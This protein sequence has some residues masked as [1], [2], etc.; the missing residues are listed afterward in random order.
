M[1]LLVLLKRSYKSWKSHQPSKMGASLAYYAILSLAPLVIIAIGVAGLVFG[2]QAARQGLSAQVQSLAGPEGA[3]VIETMLASA[4]KPTTGILGTAI[5]IVMLLLGASGVFSELKDSLNRIWDLN[6]KPVSGVWAMVRE[7][8][9]TF[10]MVLGIGFLLL[11]SLIL[12]A[13]LAGFGNLVGSALP[14]APY[15]LEAANMLVSLVVITLLFAAIYHFLPAERLPWNDLWIGSAGTAILFVAG[16][17]ILGLYLGQASVGSAYGA[18]G[19]LIVLLV[20]IYYTAQ[21][22]FYGAEFTRAYSE[23]HGSKRTVTSK[24]QAAAGS[25]AHR[26]AAIQEASYRPAQAA[27]L[28]SSTTPPVLIPRERPART[29]LFRVALS[30][31]ILGVSWWRSRLIGHRR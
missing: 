23:M 29:T 19:P 20:W 17:F 24:L 1:R 11:V 16:K 27:K 15:L 4:A 18:A 3:K 6:V 13:V 10:G 2:S 9:L 30:L 26:E 22:F 12:S 14:A 31:V 7:R 28:N 5:G 25:Q 8:F 21:L